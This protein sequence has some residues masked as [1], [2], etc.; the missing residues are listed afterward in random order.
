MLSALIGIRR[1]RTAAQ[2]HL[3]TSRSSNIDP[4]EG[5][6]P[7][8]TY[9]RSKKGQWGPSP[10]VRRDCDDNRMIVE[11]K[12]EGINVSQCLDRLHANCWI[13]DCCARM[14]TAQVECHAVFVAQAFVPHDQLESAVATL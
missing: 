11:R 4:A 9:P 13:I 8:S 5:I 1:Q 2:W 10:R 14:N 6:H 3:R 7:V 12:F